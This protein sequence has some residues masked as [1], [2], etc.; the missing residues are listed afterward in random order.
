MV[1]VCVRATKTLTCV[2]G[3]TNMVSEWQEDSM[4]GRKFILLRR[5]KCARGYPI[6]PRLI[7]L[8]WTQYRNSLPF[9]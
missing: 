5:D 1:C 3:L 7:K 4:G 9:C 2:D 8:Y 6:V